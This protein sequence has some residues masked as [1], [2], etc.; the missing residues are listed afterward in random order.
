M[1]IVILITLPYYFIHYPAYFD[2]NLSENETFRLHYIGLT[3]FG[4]SSIG[5]IVNNV[6]FFIKDVLAFIIEIGLNISLIVL[7]RKHINKKTSMIHMASNPINSL[8]SPTT[9]GSSLSPVGILESPAE[10]SFRSTNSTPKT[11]AS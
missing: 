10:N 2:V 5:L 11:L 1:F 6:L 8:Q 7:L 4:Q 3:E 9:Q